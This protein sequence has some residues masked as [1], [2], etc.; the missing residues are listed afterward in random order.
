MTVH[1]VDTTEPSVLAHEILTARPYAFL[2]DE[3]LQNRRTNAVSLR[4]GL[5][6]R[7]RRR[8][9]ASIRTRSQ[10]VHEEITPSP[11]T[12][13]D[14]HDL[15]CSL[16]MTAP[17]PEWQRAVGRARRGAGACVQSSRDGATFWCA[18]EI[19]DDARRVCGGDDA[20]GA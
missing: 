1:T 8:S 5:S 19:V 3:E 15:L 6:G 18:T 14:L 2:D 9:G 17:R 13:D 12:A 16:V 20:D 4:R 10:R 11:E 7:P